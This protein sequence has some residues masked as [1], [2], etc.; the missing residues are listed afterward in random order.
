MTARSAR[1]NGLMDRIWRTD[2]RASVL[3]G[4]QHSIAS[5][6]W[7]RLGTILSATGSSPISKIIG[8]VVVANFAASALG[9]PPGATI[10]AT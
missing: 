6:G 8:I 1:R 9:A 10:T 2:P 5:P 3:S 4:S 7:L